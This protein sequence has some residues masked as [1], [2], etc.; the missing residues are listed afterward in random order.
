MFYTLSACN[1]M[2]CGMPNRV[3]NF[4]TPLLEKGLSD[5]EVLERM[6]AEFGPG[7]WRPHLLR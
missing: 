7:I 5:K 2:K 3:R 1:T 4:V 6:E